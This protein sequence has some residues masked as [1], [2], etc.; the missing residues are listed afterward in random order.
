MRVIRLLVAV[1]LTTIVVIWPSVALPQAP[2]ATAAPVAA[3]A[4]PPPITAA[5]AN[6]ITNA[7]ET[8]SA[9]I[10]A[11]IGKAEEEVVGLAFN[12]GAIFAIAVAIALAIGM[13]IGSLLSSLILRSAIKRLAAS[14]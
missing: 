14:Q 7:G 1:V 3:E 11:E 5:I 2:A 12:V 6:A 13:I 10:T 9:A 4:T 8:I